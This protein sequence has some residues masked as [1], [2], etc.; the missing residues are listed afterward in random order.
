MESHWIRYNPSMTGRDDR[1]LPLAKPLTPREREILDCLGHEMSNRQIAEHL[2]VSLN[3]VKFHLKN[4]SE[5]LQVA[6]RT[7][8]VTRFLG[9]PQK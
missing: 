5:K 2:T 3:T 9:G 7:Q 1:D 8:A 4:L 6:N